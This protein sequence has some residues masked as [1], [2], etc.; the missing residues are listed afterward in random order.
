[1]IMPSASKTYSPSENVKVVIRNMTNQDYYDINVWYK[2]METDD[3]ILNSIKN[4][5]VHCMTLTSSAEG[6]TLPDV[7]VGSSMQDIQEAFKWWMT[8]GN[9][10]TTKWFLRGV[11]GYE[12]EATDDPKA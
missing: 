2:R 3:Q 9:D 6:L 10:L 7:N 12:T 1:M 5:F 4:W 8:L 11:L